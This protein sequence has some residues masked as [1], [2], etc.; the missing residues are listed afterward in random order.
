M[1]I[2]GLSLDTTRTY[3]LS[4]DPAKGTPEATQFTLGALDSRVMG[5]IRDNATSIMIDRDDESIS[6]NV[7]AHEMRFQTCMF[8]LRGWKN[9]ADAN[10]NQIAFATSSVTVGSVPYTVVDPNVLK[11]LPEEALAELAEAIRDINVLTE[12]QAGN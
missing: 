2:F 6:T 1:P 10:G 11:R 3:E 4:F 8:G 12:A 9:F 7:N 5:R